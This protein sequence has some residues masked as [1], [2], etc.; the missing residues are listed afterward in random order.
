MKRCSYCGVTFD[1]ISARSS[2]YCS[3]PCK[4]SGAAR[5]LR[6]I[7]A[8]DET[9]SVGD[10]MFIPDWAMNPSLLPKRPPGAR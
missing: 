6:G 2:R 5:F 1:I 10:A 7:R 9:A 4:R 3:E 8:S